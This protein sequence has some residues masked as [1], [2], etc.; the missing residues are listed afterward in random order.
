MPLPESSRFKLGRLPAIGPLLRSYFFAGIL[1]VVP[2][3][4]IA[5]IVMGFLSALW[6][7]N[8]LLPDR[9]QPEVF[10]ENKWLASLLTVGFT[11]AVIVT[12]T[13]AVSVVGWISRKYLGHKLL[14][15]VTE[16][17]QRIPVVRTIYSALDQLRGP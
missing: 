17:I 9:W 6:Q 16:L 8:D 13:I 11:I 1:V 10:V 3:G 14:D 5:W 7:L 4:I 15:L 2:L 12:L